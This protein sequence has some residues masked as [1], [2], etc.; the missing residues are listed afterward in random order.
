MNQTLG[1]GELKLIFLGMGILFLGL[2]IL[3]AWM[4]ERL[5]KTL[6]RGEGTIVG[7]SFSRETNRLEPV[8][9]TEWN[10]QMITVQAAPVPIPFLNEHMN[11]KV[12]VW[13][14]STAGKLS[15]MPKCFIETGKAG[16]LPG[17][18]RILLMTGIFVIA[19]IGMLAAGILI[20]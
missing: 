19:G 2:G 3:I 10:G 12:T 13:I 7:S 5:R 9:E 17:I 14:G 16:A 4:E 11:K 6:S 8:V 1:T 15:G 20:R 18:R